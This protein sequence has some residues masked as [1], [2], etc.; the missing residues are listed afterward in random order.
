MRRVDRLIKQI[1]IQT[2]NED[3]GLNYGI[4]TEEFLQYIN[5]AQH[6]LQSLITAMHEHA[7]VQEDIQSV[8]KGKQEYALPD[9]A[10]MNNKVV[11]VEY[12]PTTFEDDYYHL[13]PRN[14]HIRSTYLE[15]YPD[16]Y[17]RRSG[18][19]LLQPTPSQ[20]G[21][22]RI[23][24]VKRVYDL[25]IRR[26]VISV[27]TQSGNTITSLLA[28]V[29][30]SKTPLDFELLQDSDY[31][32]I[33]D[34]NGQMVARNIPIEGLNTATG[35]ISIEAGFQLDGEVIS[36]GNYI[37]A[38]KDVVTHSELPKMTER[39]LIAYA[40]WKIL[41]RDSSVDSTEQQQELS[42]MEDD[43][44]NAFARIDGD[45]HPIP[46]INREW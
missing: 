21:N 40:A 22:L 3:S 30:S 1:R 36:V 37:T 24:Y 12:S 19:I 8:S 17:I 5:D 6:R 39:Y 2:E 18:K 45:L 20:S 41:K 43:I 33:V 32:C 27:A 34:K 16:G 38:G 14:L 29:S 13:T 15:A 10:L 4:K 23:N 31:I 7:F 42:S 11:S 35:E 9:L 25:D 46:L 44:V 28:D 26:G